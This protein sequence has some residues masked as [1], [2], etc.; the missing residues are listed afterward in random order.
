ME[1]KL[2]ASPLLP[3]SIISSCQQASH[4]ES[5]ARQPPQTPAAVQARC[6]QCAAASTSIEDLRHRIELAL[7]QESEATDTLSNDFLLY[8]L[9]ANELPGKTWQVRACF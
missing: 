2:N 9:F 4:S 8:N 3:C 6:Q 5:A 1:M 7:L